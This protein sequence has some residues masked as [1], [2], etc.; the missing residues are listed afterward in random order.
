MSTVTNALQTRNQLITNT[1][2]SKLQLGDNEHITGEYTDS[3]AGSTLEAGLLM[4]KIKATGKLVELDPTA[5]DGSQNLVG[6][7]F[8]GI[9]ESVTVAASATET[10]TLI[11]KGRVAEAKLVM[12]SGVTL[13][14]AITADVMDRTVRDYANA[15]GLILEG[16][17]ELTQFDNQ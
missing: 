13:D 15:L 2:V 1:N 6:V 11:N 12:P 5:S 3:G 17:V 8:L 10:L 14:D 4:G 9:S 16:G 7:L